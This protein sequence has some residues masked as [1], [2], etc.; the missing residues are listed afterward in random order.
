EAGLRPGARQA[1]RGGPP[2]AEGAVHGRSGRDSPQAQRPFGIRGG[3][4]PPLKPPDSHRV[5]RPVLYPRPI[6][7]NWLESAEA[8]TLRWTLFRDPIVPQPRSPR[9]V[10][11]RRAA[12]PGKLTPTS[13]SG[14]LP[15][16]VPRRVGARRPR[17]GRELSENG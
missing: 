4:P 8:G 5:P 9:A 15:P 11:Q 14:P 13:R 6:A 17:E 10:R 3:R 2:G 12:R 16:Q 1:H 7:L